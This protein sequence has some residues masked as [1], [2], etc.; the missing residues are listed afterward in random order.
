MHDQAASLPPMLYGVIAVGTLLTLPML[1]GFLGPLLFRP[2]QTYPY[3]PVDKLV[4]DSEWAFYKALREAVPGKMH[5]CLKVRLGDIIRCPDPARAKKFASAIASKHVD[6]VLVHEDS[7]KVAMCIEVDDGP[8]GVFTLFRKN[9]FVDSAL[10]AAGIPIMR[11]R[12]R[13][14]YNSAALRRQLINR[15][16]QPPR[17][18]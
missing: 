3:I 9:H 5:I 14:F 16:Y 2:R 11:I 6:F 7:S 1:F 17:Y 13:A 15:I 12:P 18:A 10:A 8:G 4:S